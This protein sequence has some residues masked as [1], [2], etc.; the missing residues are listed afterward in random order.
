MKVP[1]KDCLM[2]PV[3]KNKTFRQ[4]MTGCSLVRE[5]AW[6][7]GISYKSEMVDIIKPKMWNSTKCGVL[8][9]TDE[10]IDRISSHALKLHL[11][12][13]RRKALGEE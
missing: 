9:F 4:L 6:T 12:K 11:V 10:F 5:A 3:C 13:S 8:Y 2:I 7:G 1:C